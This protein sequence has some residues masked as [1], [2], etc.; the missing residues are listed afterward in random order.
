[1]TLRIFLD[2]DGTV[3]LS[4]KILHNADI[5]LRRLVDQGAVIYYMTNNTSLSS[6]EY[7]EKLTALGLPLHS[8]GLITP[9][10]VLSEWIKKH[11]VS[12]IYALGTD[13]FCKEIKTRT[14][15]LINDSDNPECVII[16]FDKELTYPKLE[17]ACNLINAGV[18]W[19]LTHIDLA[20]PTPNGPI[21]DCGSIGRLIEATTGI[22]PTGHFGK[23]SNLMLDFLSAQICIDDQY[24][25]AGDR[26]Y[27]DAEIGIRMG[28][29]TVLV[30]TGE[31]EVSSQK[32]DPNI[33]IYNT[34]TTLLKE[35]TPAN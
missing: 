28:A 20:C 6:D 1:M 5:E 14:D 7:F 15:I 4:G 24:I 18:P 8:K 2:L 31:F 26:L 21:P 32:I 33:E 10:I 27:T 11:R 30:C 17:R 13:A 25:V 23:P 34:L 12:S 16:A 19:Y 22:L 29:R 3:Y 9:T 35:L